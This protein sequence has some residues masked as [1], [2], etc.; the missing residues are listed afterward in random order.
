MHALI[1]EDEAVIAMDLSDLITGAGHD[2]C[3]METTASGAVAAA[4][5]VMLNVCVD[6]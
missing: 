6:V 3:A 4:K 5:M 1:I 2:V